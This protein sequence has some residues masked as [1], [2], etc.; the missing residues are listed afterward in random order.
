MNRARII[1]FTIVGL[2]VII[3]LF[4]YLPIVVQVAFVASIGLPVL[5]YNTLVA[6]K[7]DVA[8]AESSVDVMLK[9]R[10]DLI[11]NLVSSVKTYMNHEMALLT[12]LSALRARLDDS[13]LS[14]EARMEVENQ[15]SDTISGLLKI[16]QKTPE[17]SANAQFLTLQRSLKESEEQISAARRAFN[18]AA[19]EYNNS[20]EM[21]PTNIIAAFMNLQPLHLFKAARAEK[22]NVDVGHL[23]SQN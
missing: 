21:V 15:L 11:P 22:M 20:L 6:K 14:L 7:N 8:K 9:K 10:F 17:L 19:T 16:A 23:F 18:A 2:A 4:Q 1:F 5:S 3:V 12:E 13:D